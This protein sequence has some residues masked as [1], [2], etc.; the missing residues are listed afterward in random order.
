MDRLLL[1]RALQCAVA[2]GCLVPISTGLAGIIFGADMIGDDLT[3]PI[4]L[5][6]HFRYLSGLLL[7]IGLLFC[8]TIPHI[9]RNG[10]EFRLLAAIVIVGGVGRLSSLYAVGLPDRPM[11]F[12]LCMELLITPLLAVW[13]YWVARRFINDVT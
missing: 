3:G 1:K 13:Q 10:K 4:S 2:I 7:G 6:S 8:K 9:E 11:L 5:D 12:G